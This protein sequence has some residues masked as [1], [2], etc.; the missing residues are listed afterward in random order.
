MRLNNIDFNIMFNA[1]FFSILK[2]IV[3]S[4]HIGTL[5]LKVLSERLNLYKL[6]EESKVRNTRNLRRTLGTSQN[7]SNISIQI[8]TMFF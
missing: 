6:S 7:I 4:V 1:D 8:S 3:T 2:M 5:V